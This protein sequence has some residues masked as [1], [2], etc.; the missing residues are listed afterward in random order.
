MNYYVVI[1]YIIILRRDFKVKNIYLVLIKTN[2]L[3]VLCHVI[4][5]KEHNNYC[6]FISG[7]IFIQFFKLIF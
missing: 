7:F 2:F 6:I 5:L 1:F 4:R 3:K